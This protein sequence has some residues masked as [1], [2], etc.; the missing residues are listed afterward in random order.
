MRQTV[1]QLSPRSDSSKPPSSQT[2]QA[3]RWVQKRALRQKR[4]GSS[5]LSIR[6]CAQVDLRSEQ[7]PWLSEDLVKF[8]DTIV[9]MD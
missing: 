9:E 7:R 5:Q 6:S 3:D 4:D 2:R 1:A 8:Y